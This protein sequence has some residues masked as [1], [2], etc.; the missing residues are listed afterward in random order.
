MLRKGCSK[1]SLSFVVTYREEKKTAFL[2]LHYKSDYLFHINKSSVFQTSE[3]VFHTPKA[4]IPPKKAK[5]KKT[6]E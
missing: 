1:I 2:A 6:H 4:P 5:K 3:S